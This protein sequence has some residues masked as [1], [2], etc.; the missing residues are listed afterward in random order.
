MIALRLDNQIAQRLDVSDVVQDVLV[1][2]SRRLQ[3]YL[4]NPGMAFH[5][6]IR[7][8]AKDRIIDAHRRHRVSSRRSVDREQSLSAPKGYDES[9]MQLAAAIGDEGLTPAANML[10][11]EIAASIENA[12]AF[13]SWNCHCWLTFPRDTSALLKRGARAPG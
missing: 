3:T 4:E 9:S 10:K 6:W 11:K 7:Q 13:P 5:L 2:A 1:E 8:I 12:I